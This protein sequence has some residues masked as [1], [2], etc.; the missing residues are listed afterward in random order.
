MKL[1]PVVV[2]ALT[3]L[4]SAFAQ[5]PIAITELDRDT[6][7]DFGKEVFPLL[8]K[9]CIA[10]HNSSKAKGQLNLEDPKAI[11]KGG[12]E[13]PSIV[14]GKPDESYLLQVAAH[15]EDPIMPPEK[16]KA[17]A[18][19]LTSDELGLIKRWIEEGAKGEAPLAAVTPQH[20]VLSKRQDYPVYHMALGPQDQFVAASRGQRVQLYD[21]RQGLALGQL[22]DPALAAKEIYQANP[23][24]HQDFVQSIAFSPE[25]W[26][27]TG[28]FRNVKLWSP[29]AEA[30]VLQ[31]PS[32][33]E[34][35]LSLAVSP[36]GKWAV[37]GDVAGNVMVWKPNDPAFSPRVEKHHDGNVSGLVVSDL[38]GYVSCGDDGKICLVEEGKEPVVKSTEEKLTAI[39]RKDSEVLVATDSGKLLVWPQ[40]SAEMTSITAH[41]KAITV[42]VQR[43][44]ASN[45][46]FTGSA[47]GTIKLWDLETSKEIRAFA[48]GSALLDL[49]P[50]PD[51]RHLVS[52]SGGVAKVWKLEDGSH[53]L[54]L[55][56]LPEAVES[57]TQLK[58]EE[59]VQQ[60]LGE[61]RKKKVSEL[62]KAWKD[63][64]EKA[65]K[66]A[67]DRLAAKVAWDKTD[68]EAHRATLKKVDAGKEL[69]SAELAVSESKKA[70][71]EHEARAK[72]LAERSKQEGEKQE[73]SI[74]AFATQIE[75]LKEA[76][77][78]MKL[79]ASKEEAVLMNR[80][81][82]KEQAHIALV[83]LKEANALSGSQSA[84]VAIVET[85]NLLADAQ[86]R[87]S[88][89][90]AK[91][92]EVQQK[93]QASTTQW[94]DLSA[95]RDEA[96]A[97]SE[98]LKKS[99]EDTHQALEASKS[100]LAQAE[101][102]SKNLTESHKKLEEEGKK[103]EEALVAATKALGQS[104]ENEELSVR[105]SQR[106]SEA[107]TRA[108]AALAAAE[109]GLKTAQEAVAQAPKLEPAQLA[110]VAFS[111]DGKQ[112]AVGR[113]KRGALLFSGDDGSPLATLANDSASVV[114]SLPNGRWLMGADKGLTAWKAEADWQWRQTI[115]AI[116]DPKSLIDR[117]TA[118]AFSPNGSIL[119]TGSGSPSRSGELKL[120]RVADGSLFLEVED[121][122]SDTIV[123]VEFSPDGQ[124]VATASTD[125]F[126]KVFRV[127]DGSLV[128]AFEGHTSHV[129]DVSWRADGLV[130]ATAGADNVVKLWDFEEKR[131]LKTIDGYSQEIT[132][133]A[134]ADIGETLVTSSGDKTVRIG[135]ERLD[136]K[137]FV[138]ASALS[139]DGEWLVAA[140]QDSV[141][142]VWQTKAKKLVQE[143]GAP[144]VE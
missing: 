115:G 38:G 88:M 103:A 18:V 33:P 70:V 102:H 12:S 81:K 144:S 16:N 68:R 27:A 11:L 119:A 79:T 98:K 32:L 24:A 28:G 136:G 39:I 129:L 72:A 6:P 101:D 40:E 54:D 116:D 100:Q 23:P 108:A 2:L 57:Q 42:L 20:W 48:H 67:S 111:S 112:F 87:L 133:V 21:L 34:T 58:R 76:A 60:A 83:A 15:L 122:H 46:V 1:L 96:K 138:Y 97:Q 73:A 105:L 82:I 92:A 99:Q 49:A 123:G 62:E 44:D 7:V 52:L 139:R 135:K 66:A 26:I 94:R 3:Q 127:S 118:V 10:C 93:V 17:N 35:V 91:L 29:V 142:R 71:E 13:G 131:Q 69:E 132:S 134:F 22:K 90:H 95:A 4:S 31:S 50:S 65:K 109:S 86:Q 137:E 74:A 25:G 8:K 14:P 75:T 121:A 47:D 51:G 63:E 114:D 78:A 89:A 56:V 107:H 113:A 41:E 61:N 84:S 128:A 37:A 120:W 45:K 125:R 64:V 5:E 43:A 30:A 36:D 126:S 55:N 19:P 104:I 141:V 9:N 140:A 117:V 77:E 124:Y 80:Q 106:A 85:E 110:A 53:L 130:L 143:F 59:K